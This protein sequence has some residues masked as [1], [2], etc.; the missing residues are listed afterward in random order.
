MKLL[1]ISGQNSGLVPQPLTSAGLVL[2]QNTG[3]DL[4]KLSPKFPKGNKREQLGAPLAWRSKGCLISACRKP[5][6]SQ[7]WVVRGGVAIR[8]A[9]EGINTAVSDIMSCQKSLQ[10]EQ[11]LELQ[12]FSFKP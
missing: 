11:E 1:W 9:V 10:K 3:K 4:A 5:W 7:A 2:Q 8:G 12:A 6:D